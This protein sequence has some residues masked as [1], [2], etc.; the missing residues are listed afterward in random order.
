M[1]TPTRNYYKGLVY[2]TGFFDQNEEPTLHVGGEVT[3]VDSGGTELSLGG[4]SSSGGNNAYTTASGQIT[5]TANVGTKTITVSGLP[6]TLIECSVVEGSIKKF[7][8]SG[9]IT[10]LDSNPFSISGSVITLPDIDD[11]VTG[12]EVC[13]TLVGPDKAYDANQDVFKHNVGNPEWDH[14]TDAENVVSASDIGAVDN[15]WVDQGSEIDC[16]T[17]K[18]IGI[19]VNFTVNDSTGNQLQVLSKHESAG[20]DEYVLETTADYQKTIG[21]SSIKIAY[22]FDVTSIPYIQIQTKATDVDTGG[23]T[24]GTV[25]IDIIKE[26]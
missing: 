15:T 22:F 21:D 2:K 1:G 9:N 7:D 14:Y 13:L 19:Y 17:Y 8:S 23:G 4:G 20:S 16:R 24:E 11:F 3:L 18:T 10:I 6:F 5:A 12:D 25:T 26:Y